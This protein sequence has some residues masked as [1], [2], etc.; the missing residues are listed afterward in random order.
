[1]FVSLAFVDVEE[2]SDIADVVTI[3]VEQ[4]G[5]TQPQPASGPCLRD[6]PQVV[7]TVCRGTV[8]DVVEPLQG[9]GFVVRMND[10]KQ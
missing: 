7:I 6:D 4:L 3:L 5:G 9:G 10:L 2:R 1:M 8:D